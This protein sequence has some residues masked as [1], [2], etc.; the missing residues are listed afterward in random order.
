MNLYSLRGVGK[1]LSGRTV[2]NNVDLDIVAGRITS[3][4]GP[5]G[6]GK[7]TLLRLLNRL[8]EPD[9]G[10][11]TY[12][13]TAITSKD[14]VSLRKEAVLVPQDSTM[15]PGSVE[16][17]VC[18]ATRMHGITDFNPADA[19]EAAGLSTGYLERDAE[20]LSGGE[21]KRV[22]LARAIALS[23]YALLLDE[24][25]SGVDPRSSDII[26][27][28]VMRMRDEGTTVVWVTH[29]I[30]QAKRV[31]DHI[32]HVKDGEAV[33]SDGRDLQGGGVY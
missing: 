14:P 22:A 16:D 7:S 8:M 1:A 29:D 28:S 24:P 23:P 20:R 27:Q 9:S 5:S 26:E 32:V 19:L 21:R 10:Q 15:F 3:L 2:L 6:S 33:M 18:Y 31:S 17:N 12:R 4:V 11:L 30:E 13:G 25:T